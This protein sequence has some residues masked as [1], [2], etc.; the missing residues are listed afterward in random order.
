[1]DDR[2]LHPLARARRARGLSQQQLAARVR[3]SAARRGLRSG[4]DASRIRKWERGIRPDA[5]SQS[6]IAQALG[7]SADIIDGPWP[8]WLPLTDTGVVPL[9]THATVPALREAL[10]TVDRRTF[11]TVSSAALTTLTA[12]WA[13]ADTPKAVSAQL[14]GDGDL[15]DVLELTARQL[16]AADP[17]HHPHTTRL[18]REHL[19]TVT[20]LL[21][22]GS[23]GPAT[24]YRLH[25][26]AA[27]I[28]H[29][30]AWRRFDN[31]D[32]AQ[33]AQYWIAALHNSHAVHDTDRGAGL[34]SD[35]AYQAAWQSDHALA[36]QLL[37]HALS[38]ATHPAARSL[39]QLRLARTHAARR[40]TRPALRALAAAEKHLDQTAGDRPTWCAW[41]SDAD[42]AV[43]S[44]Q[45]LLDLGDSARAHQLITD[46]ERLLPAHRGKTRGIFLAYQA[47]SHLD[48]KEPEPAA[49]AAI[50]S[51]LLARRIHAPRC[52][53]LVED[54]IPRF[55]PYRQTPGVTDLLHLTAA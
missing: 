12:D 54:L 1:M 19:A 38:R 23:Y 46:G 21:D 47:A 25:T 8:D 53:S 51:L 28:A 16:A 34:I 41:L 18:L 36:G 40:E 45:T 9:A 6:Y 39:L 32:N 44:G 37:I 10:R 31:G 7:L 52:I 3:D 15:A 43:D 30:L 48:L 49:T 50:Q 33:A 22:R 11:L 13:A 27:D 5:D 17:V 20:D 55:Q 26:L 2:C 29:T 14:A 24:R 42:L 35:L 4:T